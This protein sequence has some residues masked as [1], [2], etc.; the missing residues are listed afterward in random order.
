MRWYFCKSDRRLS[1]PLFN[2]KPTPPI[3]AEQFLDSAN[4]PR[5]VQQSLVEG[6]FYVVTLQGQRVHV[7]LGEW[8]VREDA[9]PDGHYCYPIADGEFQRLYEPIN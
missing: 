2:R 6:K 8:I 4:P 3:E 1:V 9:R 5:G 7:E